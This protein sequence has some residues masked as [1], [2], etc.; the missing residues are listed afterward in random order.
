MERSS[1]DSLG[2]GRNEKGNEERNKEWSEEGNERGD[3]H[4]LAKDTCF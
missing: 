3:S 4:I 2:E 1:F